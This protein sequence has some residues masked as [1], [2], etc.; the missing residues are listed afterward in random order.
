MKSDSGASSRP[1]AAGIEAAWL[2]SARVRHEIGIDGHGAIRSRRGRDRPY[3]ACLGLAR[4]AHPAAR[5]DLRAVARS[6]YPQRR[7]TV[8]ITTEGGL[9]RANAVIIATS[10][11]MAELKPLARH[12]TLVESY[13]VVTPVLARRGSKALG[14]AM[15]RSARLCPI[16]SCAGHLMTGFSSAAPSSRRCR[17]NRSAR[18]PARRAADVRAVGCRVTPRTR[19]ISRMRMGETLAL[20]ADKMIYAGDTATIRASVRPRAR[21]KWCRRRVSG[22]AHPAS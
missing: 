6:P 19:Y 1:Q 12:F 15:P 7:K 20:T 17:P 14:A 8:E 4:A 18:C 11:P 3:R 9:V 13:R 22:G 2:T 21:P 16:A 5:E 10:A